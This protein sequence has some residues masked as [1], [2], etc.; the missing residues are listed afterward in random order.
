MLCLFSST[1]EFNNRF[2][3]F[4]G[5]G[6][7]AVRHM[8]SNHILKPERTPLENSVWGTGRGSGTFSMLFE[9]RLLP[10]KRYLAA[11]FEVGT[12]DS[13]FEKQ[14]AR[15]QKV[16]ASAPIAPALVDQWPP[17]D[18][19]QTAM[20][21]NGDS[22]TL[23]LPDRCVD[24]VVTDPPYFDFIHYSELSDFF[25][26][27]LSPILSSDHA[28]FDRPNSSDPGEVQH[29][30]ADIF[31]HNLGRVLAES[32]RVLKDDGPLCFS[33]HHSRSEGW[34]AIYEALRQA[35]FSVVASHPLHSE[36][37]GASPKSAA[38]D[39]ISL[40]AVLVCRKR[41]VVGS[42]DIAD[43]QI[44]A[45]S[46]AK[47]DELVSGGMTISSSDIFVIAAG[48]LLAG[49]GDV[50]PDQFESRLEKLREKLLAMTE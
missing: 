43:A 18:Q 12:Q 42:V 17:V 41:A 34:R 2:C 38:K 13:L 5:E 35:G 47:A 1:L 32:C 9:S 45:R 19:A 36:L 7:G 8:F 16:V 14:P 44:I 26:A 20:I 15:S 28:F 4:K 31:A 11:P 40:D 23:P 29:K 10:A 48:E 21:L 39:P 6:T 37:R 46:M 49:A 30:E 25:F 50:S 27:W 3:S 24:A 33:F 22:A